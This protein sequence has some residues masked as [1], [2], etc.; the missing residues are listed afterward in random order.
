MMLICNKEATASAKK[1]DLK[2]RHADACRIELVKYKK[3]DVDDFAEEKVADDDCDE[4]TSIAVHKQ[5]QGQLQRQMK[6]AKMRH[7]CRGLLA[8]KKPVFDNLD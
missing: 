5:Q 8:K 2:L 7:L 4:K 1:R 3:T 6:V